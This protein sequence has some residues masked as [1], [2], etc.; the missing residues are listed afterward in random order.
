MAIILV[1]GLGINIAIFFFFGAFR[2]H[3]ARSY[4]PHLNRY[5]DYLLKDIGNPPDPVKA[6][7]IASETDMVISYEGN[8]QNWTTA[9]TPIYIPFE[10]IRIWHRDS[11]V[12]AGRYRSNYVVSAKLPSGRLTFLL[13]H[14]PDAEKKIKVISLALL[15]FITLLLAG[16]Y[17]AIR[18]VLNPLRGLKHGVDQVSRGDLSHRVPLQRKDELRDL[19]DAFNTMAA[20]LQ[21][22]IKAKEQLLLDISHEL[23]TP[24]TRMKVAL[25]MMADSPE[26]K[27][28][29]EDVLE[30]EEKITELLETARALNISVSLNYAETD[31]A[32]LIRSIVR[33]FEIGR[34]AVHITGLPETISLQ[35]DAKRVSR[36]LKNILDNAQ[37]YSPADAGAIEIS[38]EIEV[39]DILI[40]VRDDGIG[41]A[42]EDLDFIFEPFYRAD[43]A[44]TPQSDGYGLGLSLAKSIIEAH[45]GNIAVTSAPD[46]GTTV[47]IR[48]PRDV[49]S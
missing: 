36:A 39:S 46:Q 18:W 20:R 14:Q 49:A 8:D 3:V 28:I 25:A 22:L 4:H 11:R 34:P 40:V 5:I 43:K 31:L 33:P 19:S 48:L 24:V 26:K 6:A 10:R 35:L 44:R 37:K 2:H 13:T 17:L 30:M 47:R 23:R 1:A 21:H 29:T 41:I 32:A 15:L 9:D 16:A 42:E 45:G 38:V 7:Q 27:S 12:E